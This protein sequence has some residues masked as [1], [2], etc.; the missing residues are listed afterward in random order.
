M[1]RHE[2]AVRHPSA[3]QHLSRYPGRHVLRPTPRGRSTFLEK[4]H[5]SVDRPAL[6]APPTTVPT[7]HHPQRQTPRRLGT[8]TSRTVAIIV[9]IVVP[10]DREVAERSRG[11]QAG[12]ARERH[13]GALEVRSLPASAAGWAR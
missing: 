7:M 12:T 6:D 8:I 1:S 2:V 9:G 5:R 4:G 13:F 11:R 10:S 3:H